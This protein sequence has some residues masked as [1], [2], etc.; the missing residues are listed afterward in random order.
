M[1]KAGQWPDRAAT[2][3]NGL[4][5]ILDG[6]L[7]RER[8]YLIHGGPG[9]GKTTM[10]MQF[11]LKGV[12][13]GEKCLFVTF[14]QSRME[15]Q[16]LASS[17][18]WSLDGVELL[19]LPEHIRDDAERE[20]TVFSPAEVEITEL[21]DA[22]LD[23]IE[24][25]Q[26]DRVVIDSI[27]ELATLAETHSQ[28]R[29]LV[30]RIKRRLSESSATAIVTIGD[31]GGAELGLLQ[32][33]GHGTI[34]LGINNEVYGSTR[35]QL[36]V[37]KM[38]GMTY[39]G[40]QHDFRIERGGLSVYPRLRILGRVERLDG[41]IVKSGNA[42]LDALFG[43]GLQEGTVCLL[44]GSS[45]AGRT[46]LATMYA[47]AAAQR[48]EHA[49]V[50]CFEERVETFIRRARGLEMPVEKEIDR[51]TLRVVQH[52]VGDISPGEFA[53]GL[54]DSVADDGVRVVVIDSLS[55]YMNAMPRERLLLLQLHEVVNFLSEAGVLT[56]LVGASHGMLGAP[57]YEVD[58]SYLTDSVVLLRHFEAR[59]EVRRCISMLKKRHGP[60]EHTIR[61]VEFGPGGLRLGQPLRDF[62]GVLSGSPTYAGERN[63]LMGEHN[64]EDR[65][66]DGAS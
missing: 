51:G 44:A 35:R 43:G 63:Q 28:M 9:A 36:G 41:R 29:R 3:V 37:A 66:D 64:G 30:L 47:L 42:E 26:P 55:G 52:N 39:A 50:H 58:A 38:R 25:H 17:H 33:I 31:P 34:S 19:E 12:E 46:T 45:G 61:E 32:T 49:V 15:L 13:A 22:V 5:E 6:G 23:G 1:G 59:G 40:G 10:S 24:E 18:G 21:A 4:D 56:L 54:R 53:Q 48:G 62:T 20:Q 27:S 2:G 60:H 11:L 16:Q 65:S 14:F 7:P 57:R 8:L